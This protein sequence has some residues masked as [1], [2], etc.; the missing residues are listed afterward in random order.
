MKNDPERVRVL[1]RW[2]LG[3]SGPAFRL[4]LAK[5]GDQGLVKAPLQL[6]LPLTV[7]P[8]SGVALR[9][10][11]RKFRRR[12]DSPRNQELKHQASARSSH[13]ATEMEQTVESRRLS[14]HLRGSFERFPTLPNLQR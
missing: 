13:F 4:D 6:G 5:R 14:D 2:P 10:A 7:G 9:R 11:P 12:S 1:G 8:Q 3:P